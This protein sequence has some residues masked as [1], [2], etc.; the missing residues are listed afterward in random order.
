[1]KEHIKSATYYIEFITPPKHSGNIPKN[2]W[3]T[4]VHCDK[5]TDYFSREENSY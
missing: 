4:C 1:M 2:I 3:K 5:G